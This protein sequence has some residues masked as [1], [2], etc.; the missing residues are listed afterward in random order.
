MV[1]T[2]GLVAVGL[3]AYLVINRPTP[4]DF[5]DPD[6][7]FSAHFPNQP[8]ADAVSQ[9]NP[10]LLK[11]GEQQYQ[12][13]VGGKE[14]SVAI[15]SG[16]NAGDDLYG[17]TSRDGHING[18]AV[19]KVANANGKQLLERSATHEN[20]AARD[21]VFVG[22]GKVTAMRV[23]A[24]ERCAL[25]LEVTEPSSDGKA[26]AFLDQAGEFFAQVHV[27]AA[28]GPPIIDEPPT[29]SAADLAAAYKTAAEAAEAQYKDRWLQVT[30][31]VREV[32]E[33]ANEFLLDAGESAVLVK[34]A[35][36]ARR[37][38]RVRPGMQVTTTGKCRGLEAKPAES[39][40]VVLEDGIVAH[41][42]PPAGPP[43]GPPRGPPGPR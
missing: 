30:G 39:P 36:R 31:S 37:T 1:V 11:W 6:G 21:V 19:A 27:G 17:P 10:L 14:Y 25:R 8:Q 28:F 7:I 20:H 42:P 16:L 22:R 38:V 15:L 34:R 2:V 5:T 35:P 32:I 24:G 3:S 26:A 18:V 4:V 40:R 13:S 23:L 43:R 33:D 41:T 29:V 12:A 9:A